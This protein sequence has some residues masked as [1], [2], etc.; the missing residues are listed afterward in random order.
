[1]SAPLYSDRGK[2]F[3]Q[4]KTKAYFKR[5]NIYFHTKFGKT[6]AF[7]AEWAIW[8]VK[9]RLMATL[10]A[11][12]TKNWVKWISVTVRNLN[13]SK[14]RKH[15][16]KPK[17][18]A[19]IQSDVK[20]QDSLR[21][22]GKLPEREPDFNEI[23]KAAEKYTKSNRKNRFYVGDICQKNVHDHG[24]FKKLDKLLKVN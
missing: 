7:R 21:A 11:K 15:G 16:F 14:S 9:R 13:A 12:N 24:A 19:N 22:M 2:E 10:R 1:M 20:V 8:L 23:K 6:K 18:V 5:K 17:D 3:E 4:K